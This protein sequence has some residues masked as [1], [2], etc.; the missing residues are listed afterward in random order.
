MNHQNIIKTM[1]LLF[2]I[3]YL[4]CYTI[5]IYSQTTRHNQ[6]EVRKIWD[7]APHNAFT[8]VIRYNN[9]F[10]CTFREA[11]GHLPGETGVN[12]KI[13]VLIS[14]DGEKW[15]SLYL[16][17]K[18]D[19]DLRDPK[20]SI[21]PD[22]RLMLL[23]GGSVYDDSNLCL[24]RLNYVSFLDKEGNTFFKPEPVVI[25]EKIRSQFDWLWRVSWSNG[26]GYGVVYQKKDKKSS[27]AFLV[28]TRDGIDYSLVSELDVDGI[29]CEATVY[30]K[31]DGE[32]LILVRREGGDKY[33]YIGHAKPPYQQWEWNKLGIRLGGPNLVPID[34]TTFIIGTRSYKREG[35]RTAL[36][37]T[38]KKGPPK[39]F[40]EL[41]SGGDTGY[42][43]ILIY[44]NTLW[45]SYYSSHEGKSKIYLAKVPM[46]YINNLLL[47]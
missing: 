8:D 25:D 15:E 46:V 47:Q 2:A 33:G 16:L 41:P 11:A 27:K 3:F 10:Y 13:R 36:Y 20:L 29:P 37:L 32:M 9:K 44:N 7:Y 45:V 14:K 38:T 42:P 6:V 34:S 4:L 17:A 31:P 5:S 21:T 39:Q 18:K 43:G 28:K 1:R 22:N 12:G 24:S 23:M 35:N 19:Y 26:T 40:I 30:M